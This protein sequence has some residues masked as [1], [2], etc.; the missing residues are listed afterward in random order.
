MLAK[1]WLVQWFLLEVIK[2]FSIGLFVEIMAA[3]LSNAQ[4]SIHAAPYSGETG[5][6]PKT[7]QCFIAIAP[8][9]KAKSAIG[10]NPFSLA[11]YGDNH[12]SFWEIFRFAKRLLPGILS[13][14]CSRN[15]F[16]WLWNVWC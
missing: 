5:G 8:I 15:K 6:P 12:P 3:A 14:N 2:V 4:L 10:T 1:V 13:P 7:G 16:I 11:V 9:G